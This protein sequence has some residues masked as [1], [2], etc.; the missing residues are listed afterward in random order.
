M[1]GRHGESAPS[2]AAERS[3]CS[4]IAADVAPAERRV[5]HREARRERDEPVGQRTLVEPAERARAGGGGAHLVLAAA[6]RRDP[7]LH[8]QQPRVGVDEVPREAREPLG[9]RRGPAGVGVVDPRLGDERAGLGERAGGDGV[10]DRLVGRPVRAV[11]RGRAAVQRAGRARARGAR[12]RPAGSARRGGGSGTSARRSS[13][14]RRKR[15][16]RASESSASADAV[17]LEHRVAERR[18][19]PLEHRGAQHERLQLGRVGREHLAGEEVDDVRA[20]AVERGDEGVPVG[21]PRERQ[22]G[23]VD[24]RGPALGARDEQ[25]DVRGRRG[26]ARGAR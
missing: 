10:V 6:Q 18:A 8:E 25:L 9:D 22:R 23:E 21:R 24:A 20:R 4:R 7:R 2:S 12:A 11:P 3:P 13:S 14:G 1:T 17:V 16:V 15:F 19:Q 26:R 5:E